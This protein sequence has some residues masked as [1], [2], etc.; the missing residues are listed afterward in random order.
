MIAIATALAD[1]AETLEHQ[2][3]EDEDEDEIRRKIQ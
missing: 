2:D 1:V 3:D